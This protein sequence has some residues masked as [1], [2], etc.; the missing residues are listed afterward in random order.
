MENVK[1]ILSSRVAGDPI[2]PRILED[3]S[4]PGLG[5]RRYKILPLLD[6]RSSGRDNTFAHEDYILRSERLGIPQSRH[7]VILFGLAEDIPLPSKFISEGVFPAACV[8]DVI[9]EMPRIRSNVTDEAD[10]AWPKFAKR[11]LANAASKVQEEQPKV[12]KMLRILGRTVGQEGDPGT[13]SLRLPRHG[14]EKPKL[15]KHLRDWLIDPRLRVHLN[16]ESRGHMTSDL[17]RYAFISAFALVHGRSPRGHLD[18]PEALAPDHGNWSSGKFVDRFKVQTWDS[19][20]ST[21]TSHLSKDGHYFIHPDPTQVRSI[22]VREAARLQTF[23]DNYFFEGG[24]GAQYRQ[25]GNAVPPLLAKQIAE[26]VRS[27]I[28]P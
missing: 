23:P 12:A 10:D 20:S 5:R 11:V 6:L 18:V 3:L 9:G 4:N 28:S 24:R 7:R 26:V 16:H 19:P 21:V 17:E 8:R 27:A 2:F 15:P 25:V 1:G 13:G 14:G 22:S